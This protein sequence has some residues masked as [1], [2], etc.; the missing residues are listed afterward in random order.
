MQSCL[1]QSH[2]K[3]WEKQLRFILL[4]KNK[5]ERDASTYFEWWVILEHWLSNVSCENLG[6]LELTVKAI[7]SILFLSWIDLHF[8]GWRLVFLYLKRHSKATDIIKRTCAYLCRRGL[9]NGIM[10]QPVQTPKPQNFSPCVYEKGCQPWKQIVH[11]QPR[12]FPETGRDLKEISLGQMDW[13][14]L[15]NSKVLV[16]L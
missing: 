4:V 10:L 12:A 2:S 15:P 14:L 16:T 13:S 11:T 1:Q 9:E 5:K 8:P 7:F 3:R 6:R